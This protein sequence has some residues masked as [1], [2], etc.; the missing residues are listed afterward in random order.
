MVRQS[1]VRCGR[2]HNDREDMVV[3]FWRVDKVVDQLEPHAI[4][5]MLNNELG[6]IF[7]RVELP[8]FEP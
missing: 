6:R 8:F 5:G 1:F 7:Q 3:L 4:G 2:E